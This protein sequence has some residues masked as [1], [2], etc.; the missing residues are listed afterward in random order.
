M[1]Q[2]DHKGTKGTE[3]TR[4]TLN[5]PL[6]RLKHITAQKVVNHA[7]DKEKDV[8]AMIVGSL[9]VQG[10]GGVCWTKFPYTGDKFE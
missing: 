10:D 3:G 6:S 1:I 8:V 5:P 2:V 7:G 4:K 9:D